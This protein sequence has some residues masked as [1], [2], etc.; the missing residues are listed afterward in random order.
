MILGIARAIGETAPLLFTTLGFSYMNANPIDGPQESLPLF[1]YRNI[2]NPSTITIQRGATGAL[3]L[4]MMVLSLFALARWIGRDRRPRGTRAHRAAPPRPSASPEDLPMT[5]TTIDL[6]D[7]TTPD[8]AAKP[9]RVHLQG[10]PPPGPASLEAIDACAWFGDHLVLE[11]VDLHMPAG[12]VTSLIGP[13]GC[14]KSTFLRLLNRMHELVPERL[15][16]R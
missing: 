16:G 15:A 12:E 8:V 5:H 4:M 3:V 13:S 11:G 10:G 9:H 1:I 6:D 14:G 2:R 7:P